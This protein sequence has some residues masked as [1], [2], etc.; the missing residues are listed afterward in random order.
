MIANVHI[1]YYSGYSILSV[2]SSLHVGQTQGVYFLPE[3]ILGPTI[4]TVNLSY[5]DS[6]QVR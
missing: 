5:A 3:W 4:I 6:T 1:I 2:P